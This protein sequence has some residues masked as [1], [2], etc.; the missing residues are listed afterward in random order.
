[1]IKEQINSKNHI[2]EN[3]IIGGGPAGLTAGIYLSRS[4][5]D[6][7]LFEKGISG[8]QANL[9]EIIEN[10]PGF[11]E[12]IMGPEL[13]QRFEQQAR[14]FGLKI[15]NNTVLEISR[16]KYRDKIIFKVKTG[17]GIFYCQS[18]IVA[19]GGEASKLKVLG[20]EELTGRGVSY[21]G[22]CDG[23]FFR[24]KEI[25]VVGGG[26][27]ALEEA[28]FLTKFASKITI[29]HRRDEL[30]ATKILQERA[31]N[32]PKINFS[33]STIVL[34]IIGKSQ[35]EAVQLKNVNNGQIN[36]LPCQG[37]F[38]FTGYKPIYPSFGEMQEQLINESDYIIT[39]GNM[40]TRIEGIFACGDVRAKSL[41][42]VVT[43]CGEGA[44]AAFSVE[45][46]LG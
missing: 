14:K 3:I 26:D 10:Y 23:A 2:Y 38:I 9:T 5:I 25:V 45:A 8:G 36:T 31:F 22:T 32:N 37:V 13:M 15:M 1:M 40:K 35:V 7:I 28:L 19:S 42:Q 6:A 16:V 4:R 17:I 34:S 11:P 30:R 39:D 12:G 46:F 43:A 44:I 24:N 18:V 33:W 41:R 20:E 29:I 27:T 21:C